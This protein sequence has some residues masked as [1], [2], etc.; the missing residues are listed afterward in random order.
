MLG[1]SKDILI[2][3]GATQTSSQSMKHCQKQLLK[4]RQSTIVKF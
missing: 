3:N 4:A 1:Y 2:N